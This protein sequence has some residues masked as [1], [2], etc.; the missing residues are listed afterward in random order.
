MGVGLLLGEGIMCVVR[1]CMCIV[2][3]FQDKKI[4]EIDRER[5]RE[6]GRPK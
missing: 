2:S 3:V 6:R 5:E 4:G 1:V